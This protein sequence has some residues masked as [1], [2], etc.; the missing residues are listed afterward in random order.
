[1]R[2]AGW[3]QQIIEVIDLVD[4]PE[5]PITLKDLGVLR[6]VVLDV[7]QVR[8]VLRATKLACPG[9]ITMETSIRKACESVKPEL[10]VSITWEMEPWS[11]NDVTEKGRNRLNEYGIT[12][13]D[14][15]DVTCPYCTSRSISSMGDFGGSICKVPYHCGDCGSIFERLRSVGTCQNVALRRKVK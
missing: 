4:D 3:F 7:D 8:V 12:I 15:D 9:R 10:Q 14:P 2:S 11:P 13:E 5:I 6:S 1:M